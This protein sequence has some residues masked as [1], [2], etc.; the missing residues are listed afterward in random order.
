[1]FDSQEV[2]NFLV[3]LGAHNLM[4]RGSDTVVRN[5]IEIYRHEKYNRNNETNDIAILVMDYEVTFND[6]VQPICLPPLDP[7]FTGE[8]AVAAGWGKIDYGKSTYPGL[9]LCINDLLLTIGGKNSDIPLEVRIP[10]VDNRKCQEKFS[11]TK[12]IITENNLCAGV[13]NGEKDACQVIRA[14]IRF[15]VLFMAPWKNI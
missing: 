5:I 2:A 12:A 13:L 1:M 4:S 9:I 15:N 6:A 3:L 7:L 11:A 10:V 8:M 14:L